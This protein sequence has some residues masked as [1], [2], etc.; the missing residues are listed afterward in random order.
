MLER[1]HMYVRETVMF[2]TFGK[3]LQNV[4]KYMDSFTC[5]Q[6]RFGISYVYAYNQIYIYNITIQSSAAVTGQNRS[7]IGC[8]KAIWLGIGN[9][10]FGHTLL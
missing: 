5:K 2:D 1:R 6:F 7:H 9:T 4:S 8:A 3:V 10:L